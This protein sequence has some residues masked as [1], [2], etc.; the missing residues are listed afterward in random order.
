MIED[1]IRAIQ[2]VAWLTVITSI[3]IIVARVTARATV[4]RSLSLYD[5]LIAAALV[6]ISANFPNVRSIS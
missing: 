5:Y 3:L 2:V 1:N 4:V 6:C